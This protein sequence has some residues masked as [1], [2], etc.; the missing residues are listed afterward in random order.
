MLEAIDTTVQELRVETHRHAFTKKLAHVVT[1][2]GELPDSPPHAFNAAGMVRL[3]ELVEEVVE[4]IER[5]IDS[6]GD[7]QDTQQHL[8]GTVYEVR[9][10]M[11]AVEVWIRHRESA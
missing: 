8:A 4:A 7:D 11:E 3:R 6:G 9:R 1:A 10:R 5:R 2:L